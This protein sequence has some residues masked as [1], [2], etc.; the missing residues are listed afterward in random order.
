MSRLLLLVLI[1][2][3][4]QLSAQRLENIRA[5]AVSGG[6][7]V[8]ITY[9]ISGAAG[10]KYK[11]SVYSS[12]NNYSTPLS[13][14]SGDVNEVTAGNGKR[15][16][17]N[18]RGEMV[19]YSGDIVF[20]L[21]ADPVAAPLTVDTPSGV[22]KGKVTTITFNGAPSGQNV[23]LDLIKSGVVVNQ[24]GNTTDPGRYV[25]TVPADVAKGSDYQVRI[26]TGSQT[27]TSGSFGIK[28]KTSK[29]VYIVP[30]VVVAGVVVFLVTQKKDKGPEDLP[31]PPDP[32]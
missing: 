4:F 15:I 29:W 27:A 32:E 5:E 2:A 22:K 14:V 31:M 1:F 9:D 17:W 21:R 16:E 19:E 25:W 20:E 24:I 10:K 28:S 12:H 11:V 18:A 7:R 23:R 3:T 26:T 8:I 6:D 13:M 30:G